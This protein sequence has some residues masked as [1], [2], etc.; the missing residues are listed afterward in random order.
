MFI[1]PKM[2]VTANI[3]ITANIISHLRLATRDIHQELHRQPLLLPLVDEGITRNQYVDTLCAFYTFYEP[4]L[5][6]CEDRLQHLELNQ[7]SSPIIKWLEQDLHYYGINAAK[8]PQCTTLPKI[9]D[10][11][12]YAGFLYVK[13]GSLLGGRVIFKNLSQQLANDNSFC[14]F[15]GREKQTAQ[16]WQRVCNTLEATS[17]NASLVAMQTTAISTFQ[18]LKLWLDTWYRNYCAQDPLWQEIAQPICPVDLTVT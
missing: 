9:V 16:H 7:L 17:D 4:L 6:V 15:K 2:P 11:D 8:L 10:R 1:E 14:F 5:A 12:T 13:E 3:T 18:C